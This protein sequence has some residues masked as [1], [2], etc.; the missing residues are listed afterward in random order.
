MYE[1]YCNLIFEGTQKIAEGRNILI[2]S[3]R[4]S[5]RILHTI[6]NSVQ[7]VTLVWVCIPCTLIYLDN[8]G[9]GFIDQYPMESKHWPCMQFKPGRKTASIDNN[10][11]RICLCISYTI[12][13]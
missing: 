6:V 4:F 12:D 11:L 10:D 3:L 5:S 2:K 9:F 7:N 13:I 8:F 1:I